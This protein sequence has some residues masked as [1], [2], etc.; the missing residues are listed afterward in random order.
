[1]RTPT[2]PLRHH[3]DEELRDAEG[4]LVDLA[5]NVR[6]GT[7]P[8]WLR[9]RLTAALDGLA[10]YPDP[11]AAR[12]AV[13]RRHGLPEECVLLTAGAA[14]A[15]VLLARALALGTL[16]TAGPPLV[17]H[18]QFTEPEAALRAAGLA[19]SR[20]P[21]T[22][23]GG[24]R[25]HPASV[26]ADAGVVVVGNPT[27]PT[28]VLHPATDLAS[29]AAPGRLL[30][31]DEAFIDAVPA[32]RESL[33]PAVANLPGLVVLRSLT[34]TWGLAGLRV[35]YL[36]AAPRIVATL[37]AGQPLWPLSTPALVAAEACAGPAALAEA[38]AAARRLV[39][40]RAHLLGRLDA[41]P[42]LRTA[43]R[44][45]A[46]PFLLLRHPRAAT[47]RPRLRKLGY[48]TRRADTFPG[49]DARWLRVAVRAPDVTDAFA[50]ALAAAGA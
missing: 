2:D 18:P 11:R 13:A 21:L 43:T 15:F 35:G 19:V 29:L 6:A 32:E 42:E 26:P 22:A 40:D 46:G 27:N 1:M 28:S 48:A 49:L 31:V 24:F 12:R 25:L 44:H 4:P 8:R 7:P 5:V 37:A 47:L 38:E 20:L 39:A 10:A 36:L 14:E 3:G 23:A 34:K 17:V 16:P 30:V 9:E 50:A 33:A 41:F 45:P